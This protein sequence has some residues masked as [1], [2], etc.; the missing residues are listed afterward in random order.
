MVRPIVKGNLHINHWIASNNTVFQRLL[1]PI[2]NRFDIFLGHST[3]NNG[4]D[5]LKALAALIWLYPY[6][7]ITVLTMTA[8][9]T[10]MLPLS[11]S[12]TGNRLAVGDL[13]ATN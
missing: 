9:L 13:R 11:F 6:P 4:I 10:Y 5:E 2:F 1:D 3:A 7:D 12:L 8:S